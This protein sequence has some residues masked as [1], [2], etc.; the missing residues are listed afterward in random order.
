MSVMKIYNVNTIKI[1][2]LWG[3]SMRKVKKAIEILSIIMLVGIINIVFIYA[4]TYI[5]SNASDVYKDADNLSIGYQGT[6]NEHH[7]TQNLILPAKGEY[8]CSITW[9]SSQPKYVTNNGTVNRS[10]NGKSID[11][12]LTAT[13]TKGKNT[14]TKEFD[15]KAIRKQQ[16]PNI[17]NNT[18]QDIKTLN[19]GEMPDIGVDED[20][21]HIYSIYGKY[22][23][24]SV[25]CP[26]DAIKSLESVKKLFDMN[27]LSKEFVF[28]KPFFR[29][30]Q[31]LNLT[32]YIRGFQYITEA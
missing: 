4:Y 25:E 13:I 5:G 21:G 24:V 31:Y 30:H 19:G 14:E 11:V 12:R 18:L 7:V 2:F 26:D 9:E 16:Y 10:V 28:S 15:I 20:T 6:D 29:K 23:N 1:I 17:K 27:N 8:G 3:K 22:T 32:R